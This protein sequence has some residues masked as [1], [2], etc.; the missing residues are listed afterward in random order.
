M[1]KERD[2]L[3]REE[4]RKQK[5]EKHRIISAGMLA[6]SS[7]PALVLTVYTLCYIYTILYNNVHEE[8][9]TTITLG[10]IFIFAIGGFVSLFSIALKELREENRL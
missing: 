6:V 9:C 5:K 3:M 2:R 10:V 4:K 8:M 7:L 1:N